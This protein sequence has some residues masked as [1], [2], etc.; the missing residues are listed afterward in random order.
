VSY[1]DLLL[2]WHASE[3]F[4]VYAGAVNLLDR[5]PPIVGNDRGIQGNT[6][7]THY[8]LIGRRYFIGT[9]VKL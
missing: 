7:P 3:K 6:F 8:D 2:S 4:E 5:Q 9:H 1:I